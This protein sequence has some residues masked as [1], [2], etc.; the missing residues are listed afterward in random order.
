[1]SCIVK[2]NECSVLNPKS[3]A[4]KS[5]SFPCSFYL[6]HM[7]SENG[8]LL[9]FLLD[10]IFISSPAGLVQL[11][12][13]SRVWSAPPK[14]GEV[15]KIYPKGWACKDVPDQVQEGVCSCH[16]YNFA[17]SVHVFL[18]ALPRMDDDNNDYANHHGNDGRSHVIDYSS[19]P[20]LSWR[21]TI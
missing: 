9:P 2:R 13:S 18:C 6:F 8:S 7:R 1:M 17:F 10:V 15:A 21:L 4:P 14:R 5:L 16:L 12:T 19:H 20:H 3:R 11:D